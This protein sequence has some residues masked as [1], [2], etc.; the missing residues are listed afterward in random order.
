MDNFYLSFR[1][2]VYTL[3]RESN[4][5]GVIRVI[6]RFYYIKVNR[7]VLEYISNQYDAKNK[8]LQFRYNNI[9]YTEK[10]LARVIN[11]Y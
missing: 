2:V 3:K 7:V 11:N 1:S 5:I 10:H 9:L 8:Y 4:K 6:I